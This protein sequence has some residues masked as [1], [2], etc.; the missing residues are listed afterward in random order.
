[1][2]GAIAMA[3]GDPWCGAP[4]DSSETAYIA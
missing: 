1:V 4:T 2:V 3:M